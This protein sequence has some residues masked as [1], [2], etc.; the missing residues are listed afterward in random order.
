[1]LLDFYNG[2]AEI[3]PVMIHG[4]E[5]SWH[6]ERYVVLP[7]RKAKPQV[8][9]DG[10]WHISS[11]EYWEWQERETTF[12]FVASERLNDI[13]R[14]RDITGINPPNPMEHITP[15]I[16]NALYQKR[17]EKLSFITD[18][19]RGIAPDFDL[20]VR[21]D[22]LSHATGAWEDNGDQLVRNGIADFRDVPA[23]RED[24]FNA[25]SNALV[26]SNIRDDGLA[27][28]VMERTR[29][30]IFYS[31]GL[32]EDLERTLISIGLPEWY[33][34]YLRKVRYL[35]PKAHGVE[36]LLVD[37]ILEWYSI[38]YPDEFLKVS[39]QTNRA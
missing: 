23:A 17:C 32:S 18:K 8:K 13:D 20:L 1:M 30:G 3:L 22:L 29:K 16:I 24:I 25:I 28:Y 38:N 4:E 37:I 34:G 10:F 27:L 2:V 6:M 35:F 26:H 11:E 31:A 19:L 33:A 21:I 7:E 36:S 9:E 15:G 39:E 14:L 5:D 12:S